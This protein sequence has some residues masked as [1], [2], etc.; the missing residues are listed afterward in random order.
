MKKKLIRYF[1]KAKNLKGSTGKILIQLLEMRLDNILFRGGF[2]PTVSSARQLI[3]HGHILV[4][5]HKINIPS[6]NCQLN[7]KIENFKIFKNF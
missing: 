2:A 7:D 6:Y 4:N 5:D 3:T 1:Q